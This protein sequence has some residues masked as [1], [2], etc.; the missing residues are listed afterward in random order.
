GEVAAKSPVTIATGEGLFSRFEF[1]SLLDARG[2]SIIQPDV[3]HA[4]GIT[5]IRKIAAMAEAYG[6]EVAPHQCSGPIGHV[7]SLAAMST[8]RNFLIQEWEAADDA[9]Y[10][11]LTSGTYPLQRNGYVELSDRPGLGLT[12]DFAEFKKR[13]P[14]Q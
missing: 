5:E 14:F 12:V 1:R 4:G 9:V 8:C 6:V 3:M 10:R 11:E 2:A 7:A 13:F